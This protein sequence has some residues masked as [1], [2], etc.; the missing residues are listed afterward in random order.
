MH[1]IANTF[2]ARL[3]PEFGLP[4]IKPTPSESFDTN[5]D[6]WLMECGRRVMHRDGHI[7]TGSPSSVTH[8][9]LIEYN[10]RH[11]TR[12]AFADHYGDP[13]EEA[14]A[15]MAMLHGDDA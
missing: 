8:D 12:E 10:R 3:K 7:T 1:K 11:M 6:L 5:N 13:E 15:E 9:A 14:R 2:A 4:Q